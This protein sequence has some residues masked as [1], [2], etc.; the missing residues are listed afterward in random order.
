MEMDAESLYKECVIIFKEF[1]VK[2]C[3]Y[4]ILNLAM[5]LPE[6]ITRDLKSLLT[7]GNGCISGQEIFKVE[8][9]FGINRSKSQCKR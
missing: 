2:D 4:I 8:T 9:N 6:V 3:I 1:G 7:S 5:E